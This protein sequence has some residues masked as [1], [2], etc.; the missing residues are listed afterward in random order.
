LGDIFLQ[1]IIALTGIALFIVAA[2][3]DVKT[4]RIPNVLVAAVASLGVTRPIVNGDP[5][6]AFYVVGAS[7]GLL[8]VGFLLFWQ[9]II[10]GG[11]AKLVPASA[12]LVGYHDLTGFLA[13][14][15]IVGAVIALVVLV[16]QW[17]TQ[18]VVA[19]SPDQPPP[20]AK[21]YVPY[22]VAI[23]TA[24]GVTLFFQSPLLSS[25]IR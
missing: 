1:T 9:G 16:T 5:S 22:G 21:L 8:I 4:F 20:K 25:F 17:S 3:S 11:D 23:A 24:G 10:G 6:V 14:M 19:T 15:A 13:S 2:Y 7:A 12:L 18:S